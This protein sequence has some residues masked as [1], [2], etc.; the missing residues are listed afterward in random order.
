MV[1]ES[2]QDPERNG[3]EASDSN[4]YSK[5]FLERLGDALLM[6]AL[7]QQLLQEDFVKAPITFKMKKEGN[8]YV[9]YL[10]VPSDWVKRV[11]FD[12]LFEKK[13]EEEKRKGKK[14]SSV[15]IKVMALMD[16]KNKSVTVDLDPSRALDE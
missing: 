7:H 13:L 9:Y 6:Q 14:G 1:P 3:R 8:A 10:V 5:E 4:N 2:K 15:S 11:G 16:F 12:E